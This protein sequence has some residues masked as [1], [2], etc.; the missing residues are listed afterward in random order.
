[1][2]QTLFDRNLG[3]I[4]FQKQL[5][6]WYVSPEDNPKVTLNQEKTWRM[7]NFGVI[8]VKRIVTQMY[9]KWNSFF[10]VDL[11]FKLLTVHIFSYLNGV[12]QHAE[13]MRNPSGLCSAMQHSL[14]THTEGVRNVA[15]Q[16][17]WK[18]W[19]QWELM[20]KKGM[21]GLWE[22]ETKILRWRCA[23]MEGRK[24]FLK[25]ILY[26]ISFY[27]SLVWFSL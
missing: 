21:R 1:M 18:D 5:C 25:F 27:F 20:G 19:I 7:V 3:G 24:V 23:Y 15:V 11:T 2:F 10:V 6:T 8:Y 13:R 22:F 26:F 9:F 16:R 17:R 12:I 4:L 14:V